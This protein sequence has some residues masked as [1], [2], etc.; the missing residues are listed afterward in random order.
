MT[1]INVVRKKTGHGIKNLFLK[2]VCQ[3]LLNSFI[4]DQK[5]I[6]TML[7]GSKWQERA[8][9]C[10]FLF[11]L[12]KHLNKDRFYKKMLNFPLNLTLH[13]QK[14]VFLKLQT[15]MLITR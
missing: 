8:K 5:L 12:Y 13:E 9:T 4:H 14:K 3:I 11:F 7:K 1:H 2:N 10:I 15:H 6:K